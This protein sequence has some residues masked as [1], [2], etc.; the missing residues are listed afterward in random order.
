[1]K[2]VGSQEAKMTGNLDNGDRM[3]GPSVSGEDG[4][5]VDAQ[6][7]ARRTG[8]P[9]ST[10]YQACKDGL[11]PHYRLRRAVRFDADEVIAS[12]RGMAKRAVEENLKDQFE[13]EPDFGVLALWGGEHDDN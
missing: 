11:I 3:Y 7:I 4:V 2:E 12:M 1:M 8:L 5:L 13:S 6:E 10:I 9:I